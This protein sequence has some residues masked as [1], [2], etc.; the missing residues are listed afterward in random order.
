MEESSCYSQINNFRKIL[1]PLWLGE[2]KK[3]SSVSQ[4]LRVIVMLFLSA[5]AT[6][7][8]RKMIFLFFLPSNLHEYL[9]GA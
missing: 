7:S 4:S 1:L 6:R 3:E 2:K 5:A 9:P 8:E